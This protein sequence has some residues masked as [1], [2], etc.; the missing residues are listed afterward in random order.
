MFQL[1][2]SPV[3]EWDLMKKQFVFGAMNIIRDFTASG[4]DKHSRPYVLDDEN[5]RKKALSWLHDNA[6]QKHMPNFT[7]ASFSNTEL[8]PNPDLPPGFPRS[9][10]P[11]TA[12]R[13][14]HDLG[15][16]PMP[17]RKGL[18]FD[19]HE[20]EYVVKYQKLFNQLIY[21][22][23]FVQVAAL[24]KKLEVVQQKND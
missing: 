4:S 3:L 6:Y 23:Q 18:Y 10:T 7:A 15:C 14:L 1:L 17:Y 16:S 12:R 2:W 20:R 22:C 24:K 13:W 19:G 21:H 5:C 8:L 9:I 11:Q